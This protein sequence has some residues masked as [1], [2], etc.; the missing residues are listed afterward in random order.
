MIKAFQNAFKIPELRQRIIFTALLLIV[1]RLGAHITLPGI[2]DIELEKFFDG[3]R[4]RTGGSVLDFVNLFSGGAFNQMT[5]FAL[6]IQPYISASIVM[7]LLTV[8][9]PFLEKLSK[10]PDGRKKITQYTRYAT[11]ILSAIQGAMISLMLQRPGAIVASEN[12]QI[13]TNPGIWWTLLTMITLMAGTSFVMWLGEQITER[14]IG[15]GIS[16]I[17]T[18]GILSAMPSG[19][20]TIF[21][22]LLNRQIDLPKLVIFIALGVVAIMG[23]VYITFCVRKIPVQYARRVV[24]RKVMG[25]Q[26]THIPLRVNAA[27]M[28]PIIFAVTLMQFPST[29]LG[30]LQSQFPTWA[31]VGTLLAAFS[32]ASPLYWTVYALLIIGFTYFYTAVQINPVQMADDLRKYGGFIPGIRPGKKTA[33]YINDTLTRITLPGAVFLAVIAVFPLLLQGWLGTGALIS[34]ASILIVVGV[35]LDTVSQ[36]ESY[37]TMRHYEGFLKD[38]RVRGRRTR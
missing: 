36:I 9:V 3:L 26:A 23:T 2:D 35:V 38:R 10:E 16:L 27:G 17:I 11:V 19:V 20:Q 12:I 28:I 1:Y 33:D 22:Q 21:N 31:W 13:V 6:G 7:Q 18:I 8:V 29:V 32:A 5:I 37:L 34:G 25:G 14:G 30:L 15:N 24:G 4:G